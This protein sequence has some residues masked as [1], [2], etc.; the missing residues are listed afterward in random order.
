MAPHG[1]EAGSD[2]HWSY[3]R[4]TGSLLDVLKPVSKRSLAT[5]V[6]EQLKEHIVGGGV[7]AG[8]S[9]PSE[10]VLA[11]M[12]KVNRGAI[13]EGIKRLE[14]AGLVSVNQGG[15]TQVLDFKRTAGLEILG[16]LVVRGGRVD[17]DIA[18]SILELRAAIGPEVAR[19]C[20][21]RRAAGRLDEIVAAMGRHEGD[22][23]QLQELA[24]EFWGEV[25]EGSGGL[26]WQ[27]AW[28][29]LKKSY[30]LVHEHLRHV[31]R[32]ELQAK[33]DYAGLARAIRRGDEEEAAAR[34][35]AIVA[36]GTDAVRKVLSALDSDRPASAPRA[37]PRK[38]RGSK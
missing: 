7:H 18:R 5:E 15:A 32:D 38:A 2:I 35:A 9:L 12:L 8:D 30:G 24:M 3:H 19:A 23:P 29:S 28:S 14:Q 25:V 26:A 10:R 21:K 36:R 4:T 37:R 27:L 16:A 17:T 6:Y 13:R 22:L 34:A 1:R 11:E 31:L 20:A 33:P